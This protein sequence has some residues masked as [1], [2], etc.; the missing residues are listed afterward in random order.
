MVS[1]DAK[2]TR[3]VF[4][5]KVWGGM[6]GG[7]SWAINVSTHSKVGTKGWKGSCSWCHDAREPETKNA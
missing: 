6:Q 7:I 1:R 3:D 2:T 5:E 4:E